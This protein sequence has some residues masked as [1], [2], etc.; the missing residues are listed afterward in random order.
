[1]DIYALIRGLS[2]VQKIVQSHSGTIDV[3]S[4]PGH[5]EFCMKSPVQTPNVR[6]P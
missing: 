5:T 2:L 6:E 3:Q 1:V 4:I